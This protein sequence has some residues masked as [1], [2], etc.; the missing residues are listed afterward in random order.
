VTEKIADCLTRFDG[1]EVHA[2]C[3]LHYWL[4]VDPEDKAHGNE[5]ADMT[6]LPGWKQADAS[7]RVRITN[8]G[9]AY[10]LSADAE[11]EKWLAEEKWYLPAVVG[12]H[13]LHLLAEVDPDWIDTLPPEVWRRWAPVLLDLYEDHTEKVRRKLVERG[14]AR[15]PKQ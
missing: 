9:R 1:G 15:S 4:T 3:E 10:L 5:F 13:H 7:T 12:C 8:V 11:P 2:A 14:T 6:S